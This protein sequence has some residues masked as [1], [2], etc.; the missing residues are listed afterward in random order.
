MIC[1]LR[2]QNVSATAIRAE[3][4]SVCLLKM[5]FDYR[6][7]ISILL[8]ALAHVLDYFWNVSFV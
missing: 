5:F 4:N 1:W 2:N 7:V 3:S 8:Q 6:C